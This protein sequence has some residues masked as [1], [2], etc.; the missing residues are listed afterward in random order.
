M[1]ARG[2][3]PAPLDG[4]PP[5]AAQHSLH[6]AGWQNVGHP[7]LSAAGNLGLATRTRRA[8]Q[9]AADKQYGFRR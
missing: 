4:H 1:A 5:F 2:I 8:Q 9:R 7:A 3:R 6:P